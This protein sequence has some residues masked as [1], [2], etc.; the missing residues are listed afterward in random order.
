ME[1][2][3]DLMV[4][5]INGSLLFERK[6]EEKVEKHLETCWDCQELVEL[7]SELPYLVNARAFS[8]DMKARILAKV[9]EEE[10][11]SI[12]GKKSIH[13]RTSNLPFI[14]LRFF[15]TLLRNVLTGS[16]LICGKETTKG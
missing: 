10:P 8:S 2:E 11:D 12:L 15:K 16:K 7:M 14:N 4:D 5:C 13:R 3:C 6:W 9:F 1:M